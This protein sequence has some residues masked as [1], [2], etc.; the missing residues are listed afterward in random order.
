VQDL[1]EFFWRLHNEINPARTWIEKSID[2]LMASGQ[3]LSGWEFNEEVEI[4]ILARMAVGIGTEEE[5]P[6]CFWEGLP[7]TTNNLP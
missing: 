2:C 6:A 4:A 5:D 3:A 1:A 7:N